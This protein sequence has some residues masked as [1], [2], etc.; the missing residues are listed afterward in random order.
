MSI[1][2]SSSSLKKKKEEG[3]GEGEKKN[4]TRRQWAARTQLIGLI[5][6]NG[7]NA[8]VRFSCSKQRE[9]EKALLLSLCPLPTHLSV[10]S[11]GWSF[12]YSLSGP[13]IHHLASVENFSRI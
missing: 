11:Q 8:R 6:G 1:Y 4:Y 13:M 5:G 2:T 3:K 12:I 9:K 10:V 7:M